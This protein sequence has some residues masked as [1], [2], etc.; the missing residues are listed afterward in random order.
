MRFAV[1]LAL[2]L[3]G[4]GGAE[5]LAF[6]LEEGSGGSGSTTTTTTT[7]AASSSGSGV[8]SS[9]SATTSTTTGGG[10]TTPDDCPGSDTECAVRTCAA[11]A[12]GVDFTPEGTP[13]SDQTKWDCRTAVC[14]GAGAETWA[15]DDTDTKK[16][17]KACTDDACA[18]GEPFYIPH[19]K[20]TPCIGGFCDDASDCVVMPVQCSAGG[21]VYV[22]CD[23]QDHTYS[24]AFKDMNGNGA[25]LCQLSA[26][27]GYCPTGN[28]CTVH[29]PTP[30]PNGSS[31]Y[32]SCL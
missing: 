28:D 5:A 26:D 18:N 6:P 12:C 24:I 13:L 4:C 11:G 14:D 20:G 19:P 3:C 31:V 7:G 23:G 27:L 2:V 25:N 10:C 17:G 15:P 16:D 8:A 9:S 32:G 22:G 30:A 21:Q 1:A 29:L